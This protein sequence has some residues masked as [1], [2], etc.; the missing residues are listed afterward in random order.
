MMLCTQRRNLL[1]WIVLMW[2]PPDLLETKGEV[3]VLKKGRYV[4]R[5]FNEDT[6][7]LIIKKTFKSWGHNPRDGWWRKFRERQSEELKK[8]RGTETPEGLTSSGD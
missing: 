2:V 8:L 5:W 3:T 7:E 1:D 6:N 4:L